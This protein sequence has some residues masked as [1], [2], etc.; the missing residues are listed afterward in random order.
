MENDAT[1]AGLAALYDKH[2]SL[3]MSLTGGLK[4]DLTNM[5]AGDDELL[6]RI[7]GKRGRTVGSSAP[8]RQRWCIHLS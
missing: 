6:K 7:E 3:A 4:R 2:N 5:K 8:C 1:N